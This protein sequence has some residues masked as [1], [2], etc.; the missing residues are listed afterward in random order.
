MGRSGRESGRI[1]PSPDCCGLLAIRPC[2]IAADLPSWPLNCK[3]AVEN[4][5]HTDRAAAEASS[6]SRIPS[7]LLPTPAHQT[8]WWAGRVGGAWKPLSTGGSERGYRQVETHLP[9]PVVS[10]PE[11]AW[12]PFTLKVRELPSSFG[13]L[14][15]MYN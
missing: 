6:A 11:C 4:R 2:P 15:A 3:P 5:G 9:A 12:S 14:P 8:S 1:S 13:T 7:L 10:L